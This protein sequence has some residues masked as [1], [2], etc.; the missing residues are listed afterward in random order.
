VLGDDEDDGRRP[1]LYADGT[2][3][4]LPDTA[5]PIYDEAVK[6]GARGEDGGGREEQRRARTED[7]V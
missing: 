1:L 6:E 4:A 3:G 7:L 5:P 2:R